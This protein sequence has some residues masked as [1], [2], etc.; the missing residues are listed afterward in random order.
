MH[1]FTYRYLRLKDVCDFNK[2]D[3][4][5][6]ID[7]VSMSDISFGTNYD[8]LITTTE[9]Q[10]MFLY[11]G[12][13]RPEIYFDPNVRSNISSFASI[14]NNE[15]LVNGLSSLRADLSTGKFL[16]IKQKYSSLSGDYAY[17]VARKN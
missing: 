10:D 16:S 4:T 6:V 12:K 7:A 13:E 15:E 14:C 9:L 2:L 17:V 5:D 3:Y 11:S 1:T 8:T